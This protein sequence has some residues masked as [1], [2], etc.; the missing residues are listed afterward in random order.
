MDSSKNLSDPRS[1]LL[2]VRKVCVNA[3]CLVQHF[4]PVQGIL[5]DERI[6]TSDSSSQTREP[7]GTLHNLQ[8]ALVAS[9]RKAALQG[10]RAHWHNAAST[11][12]DNPVYM[13]AMMSLRYAMKCSLMRVWRH[14]I[15]NG[16][17]YLPTVTCTDILE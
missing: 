7:L 2:R 13:Y 3:G 14:V 1:G 17:T 8:V 5:R 12:L 10:L 4:N 9:N 15:I 11:N 6:E 16:D